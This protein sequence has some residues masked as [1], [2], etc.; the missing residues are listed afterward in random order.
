MAQASCSALM[1]GKRKQLARARID[2]AEKL[3]FAKANNP[4]EQLAGDE[5]VALDY[6]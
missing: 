1:A 4:V 2:V 6:C 3:I 5:L